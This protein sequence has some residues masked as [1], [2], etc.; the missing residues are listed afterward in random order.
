MPNII[1]V[2]RL[3]E[4]S[5]YVLL[6]NL[7]NADDHDPRLYQ[8][9]IAI[10]KGYPEPIVRGA[11]L[12]K[13]N[14]YLSLEEYKSILEKSFN[15]MRAHM[16]LIMNSLTP[17]KRK[18][19]LYISLLNNINFSKNLIKMLLGNDVNVGESLYTLNKFGLIKNTT[20]KG[21]VNLFEMHD[22]VRDA[23][24][25]LYSTE[26]IKNNL[27]YM[28][29]ALNQSMPHGVSSK[30]SFI[31]SDDTMVAN[32]E[33]LLVNAEKYGIDIYK[34]LELRRNLINCY[35]CNLDHYNWEKMK[36]WLDKKIKEGQFQI[37]KMDH[38]ALI[39]YSWYLVDVGIYESFVKADYASALEYFKEAQKPIENIYNIPELRFTIILQKAQIYIYSGDITNAEIEIKRAE[40]IIHQFKKADLDT[41]LYWFV[42]SRIYLAQSDYQNALVA[43]D[44]NIEAELH[45]PRDTFTASTFIVK[46]EILNYKKDFE[47]SHK[48]IS[49]IYRQEIGDKIPDHEIHARILVQSF[50]AKLGLSIFAEALTDADLACRI[51][52]QENQKYNITTI[53]NPEYAAALIA[54]GDVLVALKKYKEALECYDEAEAI[55]LRRYGQNYYIMDDV[56][57]LENSVGSLTNLILTNSAAI[58]ATGS[59]KSK[60]ESYIKEFIHDPS[61]QIIK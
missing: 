55:Y 24:L 49:E 26:E 46:A 61:K 59:E 29:D 8:K 47:N 14:K 48:V 33:V 27:S 10:F 56:A 53:F 28:I 51:Y 3:D 38:P 15:P 23:I 42:K 37:V 9:L 58:A 44:K 45:L 32:L 17:Q 1:Y 60:N 41:G 5:A 30:H 6:K 36:L 18:L 52:N 11:M 22:A 21:D 31:V 54:N 12:L 16:N 35:N 43:I 2:H 40:D 39:N 57:C 4:Q 34:I 25:E 13:E 20:S 19:A 50:R 7:L